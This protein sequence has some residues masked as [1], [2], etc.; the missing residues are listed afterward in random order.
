M[1]VNYNFTLNGV[2]DQDTVDRMS[3]RLSEVLREEFHTDIL[4]VPTTGEGTV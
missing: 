3:S 2:P 4:I 1:F